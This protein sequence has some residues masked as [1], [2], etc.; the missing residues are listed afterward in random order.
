VTK[1]SPNI[2]GGIYIFISHYR[3][4]ITGAHVR[5]NR[6]AKYLAD[7]GYRIFWISPEQEAFA[8]HKNVCF[9]NQYRKLNKAVIVQLLI[10]AIAKTRSILRIKSK[11]KAIVVFGETTTL[12]AWFCSLITGA[13]ISAGVRS[14][15]PKR[16]TILSCSLSGIKKH[17][18]GVYFKVFNYYLMCFYDHCKQIIVQSRHAKSEFLDNYSIDPDK[19]KIQPND[20]PFHYIDAA[21]IPWQSTEA[22]KLLF[23]GNASRIKGFDLL[24]EVVLKIDH[25]NAPIE[26]ITMVGID[27]STIDKIFDN[28]LKYL[29]A[30]GISYAT[31]IMDIMLNHDLLVVPSREDQFPNVVLEAMALGLPVI[32]AKV[33]GIEFMLHEDFSMFQPGSSTALYNCLIKA[34]RKEFYEDLKHNTETQRKRFIFNWESHYAKHLQGI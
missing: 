22:K 6:L 4:P 15:V 9:T 27:Q 11:V 26:V 21:R 28:K 17:Y 5:Y 24:V 3:T 25:A 14:N 31:N 10:F 20:L 12:A 33:D 29:T 34:T 19:V 32:G 1:E 18:Q 23:I 2:D 16:L 30:H 13:P 7:N 8:K